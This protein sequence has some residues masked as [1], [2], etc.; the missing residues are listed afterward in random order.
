MNPKVLLALGLGLVIGGASSFFYLQGKP[1]AVGQSSA[2]LAMQGKEY[3]IDQ[4]PPAAARAMFDIEREAWTRKTHIVS[5]AAGEMYVQEKIKESGDDRQDV[6]MDVLGLEEPTEEAMQAFYNENKERIPAPYEQVREQIQNF[7]AGQ[8]LQQKRAELTER[9]HDELGMKV[10]LQEPQA[11]FTVIDTDGF[12]SKG[13]PSAAHTLIKF[14]DY[15]CPHCADAAETLNKVMEAAGNNIRLV[16]MDFPINRSGISR[17]V[18]LGAVCADEQG[19]FWEYNDTAFKQQHSLNENSK[20]TLAEGLGLDMAAY[21][22]CL[23]SDRPE[24]RVARSE[25]VAERLGLTGTPAFFMDGK[26]LQPENLR[27]GLEQAVRQ[28]A[29]F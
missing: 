21:Q 24:K 20:I 14:A 22:T 23:D 13:N 2:V 10:L 28:A 17:G 27:E 12:P 1:Q 9:L 16:Y 15:Q 5:S 8:D 4:L 18:A 7:L 3:T 6:L 11:P 26:A 25:A 29:G 19:M